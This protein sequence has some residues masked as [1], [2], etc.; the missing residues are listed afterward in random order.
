MT[1]MH[2]PT[3][4]VFPNFTLRQLSEEVQAAATRRQQ[5]KR[6]RHRRHSAAAAQA[7]EQ[8]PHAGDDLEDKAA[9]SEGSEQD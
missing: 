2:M 1:G 3:T 6:R 8:A 9:S 4:Q 5:A 7:T